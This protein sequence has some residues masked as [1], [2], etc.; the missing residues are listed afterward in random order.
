MRTVR[1]AIWQQMDWL[2]REAEQMR[3]KG[4]IDEAVG[5]K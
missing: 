2:E 3:R 4:W 1:S 5:C